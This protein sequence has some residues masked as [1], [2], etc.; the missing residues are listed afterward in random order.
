MKHLVL[1]RP[2]A[3]TVLCSSDLGGRG[4]CFMPNRHRMR[5]H[6][7]A[8]VLG[9]LVQAWLYID[10]NDIYNAESRKN[11]VRYS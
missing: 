7:R 8:D 3:T 1:D 4:G 11:E 10:H 5:S 9:S 6:V 2:G